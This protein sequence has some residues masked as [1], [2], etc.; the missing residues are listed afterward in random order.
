MQR[1]MTENPFSW[2]YATDLSPDRFCYP[3][4]P[5]IPPPM[6]PTPPIPPPP[7][8]NTCGRLPPNTCGRFPPNTCGLDRLAEPPAPPPPKYPI[9][10][11]NTA[12]CPV[13]GLF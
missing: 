10:L 3:R 13:G 7:P 11:L 2:V 8:G 1:V 12:A 6:P 5:P 9:V 4:R